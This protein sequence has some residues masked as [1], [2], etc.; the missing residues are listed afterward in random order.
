MAAHEL[1]WFG[2]LPD[3]GRFDHHPPGAPRDHEPDYGI[4]YL[5]CDDPGSTRPHELVAQATSVPGNPLEVAVAEAAQGGRELIVADGLTLS[6]LELTEPLRVLDVRGRF[7]Q[8]T[9]AGTHLSTAP[10]PQTQRWARRIHN[11]YRDLAGVLYAPSTGGP[12]SQ[13]PCSNARRRGSRTPVCNCHAASTTRSAGISPA[14]PP[15]LSTPT[16]SRR[17]HARRLGSS[18]CTG[19]SG[20]QGKRALGERIEQL[21]LLRAV[22]IAARTGGPGGMGRRRTRGSVRAASHPLNS[23]VESALM[24]GQ[25][26]GRHLPGCSSACVPLSGGLRCQDRA[27]TSSRYGRDAPGS[28]AGAVDLGEQDPLAVGRPTRLRRSGLTRPECVRRRPLPYSGTPQ[29]QVTN[30]SPVILRAARR[31]ARAGR[32]A[33]LALRRR[34]PRAS[35]RGCRLWPPGSA[36]AAAGPLR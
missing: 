18:P 19:R 5:A 31:S 12:R 20:Q 29:P 8:Q 13:S 21:Q 33:G 24:T 11:Q 14:S 36:P 1:R 27:V 26:R 32:A 25:R 6:V 7:A 3:K 4:A 2:P 35:A 30:G 10:H 23:V 15:T 17:S 9:R 16:S 28:G 34:G 22:S